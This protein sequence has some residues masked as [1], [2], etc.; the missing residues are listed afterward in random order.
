[1]IL[2]VATEAL[3][4][5]FSQSVSPKIRK[6]VTLYG[7]DRD[8]D[9]LQRAARLLADAGVAHVVLELRDFL[10]LE[11]VK[12]GPRRG[13][14]SLRDDAEPATPR[15][16][17][18]VIANPPY[19][20]TQVLGAAAQDWRSVSDYQGTLTSIMPSPRRWPMC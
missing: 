19:V 8:E 18:G 15:Q 10:A 20:R 1:M 12:V 3:L 5:A 7:Y 11:G 9:A 6:R 2:G 4:F 13:Q 17:D 14:W 16:F